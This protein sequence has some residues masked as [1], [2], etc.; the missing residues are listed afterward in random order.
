MDIKK[1]S[2]NDQNRIFSDTLNAVEEY[3]NDEFTL[4]GAVVLYKISGEDWEGNITVEVSDDGESCWAD[5]AFEYDGPYIVP[6]DLCKRLLEYFRK[7]Y[8]RTIWVSSNL[9]FEFLIIDNRKWEE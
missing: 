9:S 3:F 5:V 4:G 1:F 8:G 7:K 2:S 6:N